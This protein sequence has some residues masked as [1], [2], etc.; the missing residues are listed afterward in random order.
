MIDSGDFPV[1]DWL[2]TNKNEIKTISFKVTELC[3]T[4]YYYLY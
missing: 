4:L 1:G 3:V 2:S